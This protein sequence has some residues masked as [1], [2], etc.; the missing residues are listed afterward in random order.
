M[1]EVRVRF[2]F[3]QARLIR[4]EYEHVASESTDASHRQQARQIVTRIK[5]AM[6]VFRRAK[7]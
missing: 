6:E 2:T 7:P 3:R 5:R 4:S 1:T